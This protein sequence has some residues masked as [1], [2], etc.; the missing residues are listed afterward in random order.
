MIMFNDI[1]DEMILQFSDQGIYSNT[2]ANVSGGW[3]NHAQAVIA[4]ENTLLTILY[5]RNDITDYNWLSISIDTYVPSEIVRDFVLDNNYEMMDNVR[6]EGKMDRAKEVSS[7]VGH[8]VVN[9]DG[10][11]ILPHG[12]RNRWTPK[13]HEINI[14]GYDWDVAR[15]M[16]LSGLE[17]LDSQTYGGKSVQLPEIS[18]M[19]MCG[20]AVRLEYQP[21]APRVIFSVDHP[22]YVS[23][24]LLKYEIRGFKHFLER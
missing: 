3:S 6:L 17:V 5:Q 13:L 4:G 21:G 7:R 22:N 1:F 14:A 10:H 16:W 12:V 11:P 9:R 8:E 18:W 23:M 24:G 2:S 20:N 15:E 19:G